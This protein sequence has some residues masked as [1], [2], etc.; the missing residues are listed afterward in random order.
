MKLVDEKV[1]GEMLGMSRSWLAR[2][3]M[4]G[5]SKNGLAHPPYYKLGTA[6]RYSV[7]DLEEWV[8][9]NRFHVKTGNDVK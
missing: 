3:R 2:G 5:A 1:A 9:A 8:M 4:D 7:T 6:V